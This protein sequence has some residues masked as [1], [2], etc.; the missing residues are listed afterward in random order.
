[1]LCV[2]LWTT[3]E[4]R[5]RLGPPGHLVPFLG[6]VSACYGVRT[7]E[8]G[9]VIACLAVSSRPH[10]IVGMARSQRGAVGTHIMLRSTP[11]KGHVHRACASRTQGFNTKI[12]LPENRRRLRLSQPE[13]ER[14]RLVSEQ[15]AE[16]RD[17]GGG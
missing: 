8:Y 1:M 10:P 12:C 5:V 16:R 14:A 3:T 17:S 13:S 7:T 11:Y 2:S 4:R 6:R 15:P 9:A